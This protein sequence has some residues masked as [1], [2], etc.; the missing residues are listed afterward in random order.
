MLYSSIFLFITDGTIGCV[1][2]DT[3]CQVVWHQSV[4]AGQHTYPILWCIDTNCEPLLPLPTKGGC[5]S[6]AMSNWR[7]GRVY[8]GQLYLPNVPFEGWIIDS[9]IHGIL[10]GSCDIVWLH[11]HNGEVVHPGMMT[12]VLGIVIDR[13][14]DPRGPCR[15]PYALLITLSLSHLYLY[16]TPLFCVMLSLSIGATRRFLMVLSLL[17]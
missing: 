10:D 4:D 1:M 6:C 11:T 15:L 5:G 12:C 8:V 9:Y 13:G 7:C 3:W 14:R 17:K 16:I 2:S